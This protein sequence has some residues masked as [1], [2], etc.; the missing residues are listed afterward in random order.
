MSHGRVINYQDEKLD[1][2]V[3]QSKRGCSYVCCK[4]KKKDL[5]DFWCFFWTLLVVTDKLHIN[6]EVKKLENLADT[7]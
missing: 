3:Y 6:F 5:V 7:P 1:V 4:K 2:A